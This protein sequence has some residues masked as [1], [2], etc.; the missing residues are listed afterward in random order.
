MICRKCGN[1]NNVKNGKMRGKQRYKCKECGFQ[2]TKAVSNGHS[3]EEK[4][5]AVALYILGLSMRTIAKLFR[6]NVSTVLAWVRNFALENYEKPK[7]EG[8]VILELDEMWH[9]IEKKKANSGS[10]RLFVAIPASSLIGNAAPETQ[11]H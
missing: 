7:P 11:K 8:A 5:R 3:R 1:E 10:G 4:G 9:Y 6:V 2:F